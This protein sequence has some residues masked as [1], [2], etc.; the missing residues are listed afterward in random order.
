MCVVLTRRQRH[1]S[2]SVDSRFSFL[3]LMRKTVPARETRRGFFLFFFKKKENTP[4]HT[5]THT[6]ALRTKKLIQHITIHV[7][8]MDSTR[9]SLTLSLYT[10]LPLGLFISSINLSF[11][12]FKNKKSP[13]AWI[14]H[15]DND[16]KYCF[17][18]EDRGV[19]QLISP[20]TVNEQWAI[21]GSNG[22]TRVS[23]QLMFPRE[24]GQRQRAS[25]KLL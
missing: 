23:P 6:H 25:C 19:Y 17:C 12:R 3:G 20:T 11:T 16:H 14:R 15:W 4:P 13:V 21:W 8:S 9:Q 5:H 10:Q 22:T 7:F 2:A 1:K 18:D 24:K